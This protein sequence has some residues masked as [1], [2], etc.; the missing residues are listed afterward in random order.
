MGKERRNEIVLLESGKGVLEINRITGHHWNAHLSCVSEL[1]SV[2]V[3]GV[4]QQ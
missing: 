4:P 2:C 1:W 3:G